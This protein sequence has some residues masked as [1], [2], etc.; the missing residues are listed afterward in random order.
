MTVSKCLHDL[1]VPLRRQPLNGEQRAETVRP[2]QSRWSMNRIGEK[3]RCAPTTVRNV[4]VEAGV[5]R[6]DSHGRKR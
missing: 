2:Y 3:L 4:L 5:T 1:A 6:R